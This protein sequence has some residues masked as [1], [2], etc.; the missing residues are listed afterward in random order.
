MISAWLMAYGTNWHKYL[1]HTHAL[2][3]GNP[4]CA[5]VLRNP[6]GSVPSRLKYGSGFSRGIR[7]S[8]VSVLLFSYS[9][10]LL[11][12]YSYILIFFYFSTEVSKTRGLIEDCMISLLLLYSRIPRIGWSSNHQP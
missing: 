2:R 1:R 3:L 8:I 6:K 11:F 9:P 7:L 5:P 12:S 10:I 4:S